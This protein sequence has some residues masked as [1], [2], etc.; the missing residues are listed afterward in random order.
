M[1]RLLF[2][3]KLKFYLLVLCYSEPNVFRLS[4]VRRKKTPKVMSNCLVATCA[5]N[6]A[7]EHKVQAVQPSHLKAVATSDS[8]G[9]L[10]T[11]GTLAYRT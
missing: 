5:R 2:H 10:D 9:K 7:S 11:L 6:T 4:R 3:T 8:V 1:R